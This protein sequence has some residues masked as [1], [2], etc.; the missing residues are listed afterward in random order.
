MVGFCQSDTLKTKNLK[1]FVEEHDAKTFMLGELQSWG[2]WLVVANKE[3]ADIVIKLEI[4]KTG[5]G[6]IGD[7]TSKGSAFIINAKT[8]KTMWFSEESKGT[9]DL[10]NGYAPSFRLVCKKIVKQFKKKLT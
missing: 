10:N 7:G 5:G 3:E 2:Y 1:V 8:N 4:K 6:L 9:S